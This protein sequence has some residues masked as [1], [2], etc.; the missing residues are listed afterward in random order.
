MAKLERSTCPTCTRDPH[1]TTDTVA[2]TWVNYVYRTE[3]LPH[4]AD[5]ELKPSSAAIDFGGSAYTDDRDIEG[6]LRVGAPDSGA[7]ENED[8]SEGG[9]PCGSTPSGHC[10][11]GSPPTY[12]SNGNL[13]QD[14]S[15]CGCAN[16]ADTCNPDGTCGICVPSA[17]ICDGIDNDC[18]LTTDEGFDGDADT[19]FPASCTGRT[20]YDCN[21]ANAGINPGA[22]DVCGNGI[23]EDCDGA[24]TICACASG[25]VT[26][27]CDCLG[28]IVTS[29][30]CCRLGPSTTPCPAFED[31]LT[32]RN[33]LSG[34]SGHV[35][36]ELLQSDPALNRVPSGDIR[37]DGGRAREVVMTFQDIIGT[38]EDQIPDGA[39][40][41]SATLTLSKYQSSG[42]G[43]VYA[44][45][46]LRDWDL[47]SVTWNTYRTGKRLATGRGHRVHRMQASSQAPQAPLQT[48]PS[49]TSP[50]M[51]RHGQ[52]EPRTTA[53]SFTR[54]P[55]AH[56]SNSTVQA[57]QADS[58]NSSSRTPRAEHPATAATQCKMVTR[59]DSTAAGAARPAA[60]DVIWTQTDSRASPAQA[61]TAMMS[62]Q[63]S[64]QAP[65][66]S[67]ET[68]LTRTVAEPTAETATRQR[69]ARATSLT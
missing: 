27:T 62:T 17:E 64:T 28:T 63:V 66:R 45:R 61:L 38:G 34:Y 33:G 29:G 32:F 23:D 53:C 35:N 2:N 47:G 68:Q 39:D 4:T 8:A 57:L 16:Q 6:V 49:S 19:Y 42:A 69:T 51:Y 24:D 31:E 37:I 41:L 15:R 55:L 3:S 10:V 36:A 65:T 20:A 52:T 25:A 21:D 30:Y 59:R 60:L 40:I 67:A 46:L 56:S 18:D 7:Y 12:C 1:S 26:S 11:A 50:I 22:T 48:Q 13:I 9:E 58:L 14:C 43:D 44:A 5:F 54:P